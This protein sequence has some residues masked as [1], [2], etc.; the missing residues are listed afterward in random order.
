MRDLC[1]TQSIQRQ[2]INYHREESYTF[3]SYD[4]FD[5]IFP[6]SVLDDRAI[7]KEVSYQENLKSSLERK[8][9]EN[10]DIWRELGKR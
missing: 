10:V 7:T 9:V 1:E 3:V 8:L 2:E 5:N 6:A 4:T